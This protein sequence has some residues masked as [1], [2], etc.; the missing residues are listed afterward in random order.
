MYARPLVIGTDLTI[1]IESGFA[2]DK[3]LEFSGGNTGNIFFSEAL[4]RS[5][6]GARKTYSYT[7]T[8]DRIGDCDVIVIS[9]ANWVG[10]HQDLAWLADWLDKTPLPVTIVGL[11]AQATKGESPKDSAN[12]LPDGTRRALSI[13]SERSKSISVRGEFSRDVLLCAGIQNVTVTGCPSLLLCTKTIRPTPT[14]LQWSD[15]AIHGTR[16]GWSRA[17][18]TQE[19]FYQHSIRSGTDL[20]FQSEA[21]EL[22]IWSG[23]EDVRALKILSE[24]YAAP[25]NEVRQHISSRGH[26][27]WTV[28]EWA[29][30]LSTKQ[31]C[32]GSRIHGTVAALCAGTPAVLVTHDSRT[33][34]LAKALHIP[35]VDEDLVDLNLDPTSF[36]H[37]EAIRRFH[38]NQQ[39]YRTGFAD[40]FATNRIPT[41]F[42]SYV[43][44]RPSSTFFDSAI[45]RLASFN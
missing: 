29:N 34:E 40:F 4:F 37:D 8:S 17:T 38:E 9:A 7:P 35:H 5:I 20:V 18:A 32:L 22:E 3:M 6:S 45:C 42:H 11:G 13:L 1:G 10:P 16:Y 14:N 19:R 24:I 33:Q 31:A 21:P 12:G 2:P 26:F 39:T 41:N 27:F 28:D 44:P 23:K 15:V 43:S 36:F 25:P 30:F